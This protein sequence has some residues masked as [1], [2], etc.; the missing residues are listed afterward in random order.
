M[1]FSFLLPEAQLV[2]LCSEAP[3]QDT[4]A[5]HLLLHP[6]S[7]IPSQNISQISQLGNRW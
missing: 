7:T 2:K 6:G 3:E 1:E 5:K 4:A